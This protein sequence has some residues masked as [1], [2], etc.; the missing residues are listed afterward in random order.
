MVAKK[1]KIGDY[2]ETDWESCGVMAGEQG[3]VI[4]DDEQ[5]HLQLMFP[6]RNDNWA[7]DSGWMVGARH[8]RLLYRP[9]ISSK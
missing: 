3:I 6:A 8:L 4:D 1:F 9:R 7:T 2:V 5:D